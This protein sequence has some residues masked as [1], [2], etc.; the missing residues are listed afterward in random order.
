MHVVEVEVDGGLVQIGNARITHSGQDA[1]QV[2]VAGK[3]RGFH[4]GRLRNASRDAPCLG[5]VS[6]AF[7]IDRDKF[8]RAFAIA[9]DGLCQ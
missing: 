4:Q 7:N 2:G 3:K 8:C 5:F 1:A 6:R 9:R